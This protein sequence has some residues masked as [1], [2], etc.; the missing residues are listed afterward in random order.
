[1]VGAQPVDITRHAARNV[2]ERHI[3][4]RGAQVG[5]ISLSIGLIFALQRLR[6]RDVADQ[7]A[8]ELLLSL[9]VRPSV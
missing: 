3:T 2:G 8:V 6:E 4:P 9:T 1:M 5:K 7:S